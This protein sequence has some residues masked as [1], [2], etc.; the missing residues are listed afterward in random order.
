MTNTPVS[1]K[2]FQDRAAQQSHGDQP[3]RAGVPRSSMPA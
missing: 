1:D 2:G 3:K